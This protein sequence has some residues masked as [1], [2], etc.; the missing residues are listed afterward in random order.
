M[1]YTLARAGDRQPGATAKI[2]LGII[3][4]WYERHSQRRQLLQ[5][6]DHLL[7][8]VGLTRAEAA[9]EARKPFWVA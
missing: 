9:A 4:E 3:S 5:L 7:T 6:D 2:W 1:N 8:D